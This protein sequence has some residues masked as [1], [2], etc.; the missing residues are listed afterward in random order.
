MTKST[1]CV[2]TLLL[3]LYKTATVRNGD[4]WNEDICKRKTVG[5]CISKTRNVLVQCVARVRGVVTPKTNGILV[6]LSSVSCFLVYPS[7]LKEILTAEGLVSRFGQDF[8]KE[9]MLE[10]NKLSS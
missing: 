2:T 10:C 6:C 5:L 9:S 1:T 8:T 4:D 7:W 3:V